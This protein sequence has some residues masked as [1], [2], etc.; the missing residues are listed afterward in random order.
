MKRIHRL[1]LYIIPF[2]FL[3]CSGEEEPTEPVR[4][5][6]TV[7]VYIAMQ[8]S[9]GARGF[10]RADST[11]IAN[12]MSYIP[13]GDRLLMFIDDGRPPRLYELYRGLTVTTAQGG[14][15][16]HPRLVRQW[17][18]DVS[19][20]SAST[21][22]DLLEY[23]RQNYPSDSYGLV[24]ESHATGWLPDESNAGAMRVPR[25]KTFG[26]DVGID[27]NM[28]SDKGVAGSVTDQI[29]IDDLAKTIT[30]SGIHPEY[31][32]FDACLMQCIE[33]AYTLRNATDYIIASP[34]SISGEGGYYTDLVHYGLFSA[35]AVD[36]ARVYT[37]YY[38]GNGSIP[39]SDTYGTVMSCICTK[40]GN[41]DAIASTMREIWNDFLPAMTPENRVNTLKAI[42]INGA[43]NY[44]AYCSSYCYRP[45][46]YDMISVLQKLGIK[47][48]LLAK[49]RRDLSMAVPYKG[50]T[51]SY[52]IGP[53]DRNFQRMPDNEDDWC[54][55]SMFIPQN[56][57]SYHT[58]DC[59]F[60]DLN[61]RYK[62][63]EWYKVVY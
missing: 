52:L 32:L 31:I 38:L 13:E 17:T 27:G 62:D 7:L 63:T 25:R 61:E 53:Y 16:R 35:D 59:S 18:E 36:V 22:A 50:A 21:L 48:T 58:H 37:D 39:Y 4:H 57:Y 5:R 3:A 46:Y 44:H 41:L 12:A 6:R 43:L 23:M 49:L 54:G 47:E 9:L 29:S 15:A 8:N 10:H 45:H 30:A 20:G 19:S 26:V 55:V 42:N 40:N 56:I 33:V 1:L 28:S 60:G 34:I 51:S 14:K 11:E 24:M 2:L